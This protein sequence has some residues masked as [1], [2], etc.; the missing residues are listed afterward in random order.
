MLKRKGLA[1]PAS[2]RCGC[3]QMAG[4]YTKVYRSHFGGRAVNPN[5]TKQAPSY[6]R[7]KRKGR[8]DLAFVLLA[9][10]R[11]YL[12]EHGSP[13][14]REQYV[15]LIREW[16]CN[17][18]FVRS[19][20][21]EITVSEII[22][23]WMSYAQE[24]YQTREPANF[25]TVLKVIANLYG[26]I[27]AREFGPV[28][29]EIVR[30]TLID[31]GLSRSYINSQIDRA[32]R[33]FRWSLSKNLI[34]AEQMTSLDAL[35]GLRFGRSKARET[36]PVRPVADEVI[37]KTVAVMTPT[38]AAMV[39]LQRLTGMRSGELVIMRTVDLNM[40]SDVWVYRP[41]THKTQ[42][43]GFDR[44]VYIGP[45]GQLV[46]K[47]YIRHDVTAYI[48]SPIQA[49]KEREQLRHESRITPMS[50]G[51][52][53]GSNRKRKPLQAPGKRY[54]PN[55]Y[56]QAVKYACRR[57]FPAPKGLNSD[58]VRAWNKRHQWTPHQVRHA[59][60]TAIRKSHGLESAQV[61][62][63]HR[64]ANVTQ[65]YAEVDRDRAVSVAA[66]VG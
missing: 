48:F 55:G 16:Q 56:A 33:V 15:R 66:K 18:G 28:E 4:T 40:S 63:G 62:L 8:P 6:R 34:T 14:S 21:A 30:E 24:S 43:R 46:L 13:E 7:Q 53:P 5:K 54:S 45:K 51:N 52:K 36:D 35:P 38:Q 50:C 19:S 64:A 25:R 58:E 11:H 37:N 3:N 20:A 2:R 26:R 42:Y 12:G 31:K 41:A 57:A 27:L 32:R 23:R 1:L 44:Q 59:Y 47:P 39:R 17:G 49:E 65:L 22:A 60:A 29:L 9:G 61:L 10:Q